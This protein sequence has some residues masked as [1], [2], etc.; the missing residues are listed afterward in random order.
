MSRVTDIIITASLSEDCN[1]LTEQ[2]KAFSS[3]DGPFKLVS[4]E[5]EKLPKGWYGGSKFIEANIFIGAYNY[6]EI[7]KLID[8]MKHQVQWQDPYVVQ[9]I[10]KQQEDE[11]FQIVDLF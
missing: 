1:H 9:I 4:I 10:F 6:L 2:F 5:N 8:F 11:K 3:G 7:E